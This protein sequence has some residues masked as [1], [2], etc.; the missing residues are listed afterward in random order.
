MLF[1]GFFIFDR[2]LIKQL[3][4]FCLKKL[5]VFG[6]LSLIPSLALAAPWDFLR[7][8]TDLAM[9]LSPIFAWIVLIISLAVLVVSILAVKKKKSRRLLLVSVAFALFSIKLILNLVDL[10]ASPGFFMNI[11]VQ[12]VFDLLIMGALFTALFR[13]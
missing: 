9:N 4:W 7:G 3:R 2:T 6:A 11:G 1:C 10:Y 8:P 12:S 5:I 13:K